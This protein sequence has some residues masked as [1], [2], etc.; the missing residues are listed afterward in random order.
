MLSGE[1]LRMQDTF[2]S[3]FKGIGLALL[4]I[5]FLMVGLDKSFVVPLRSCRSCRS[6]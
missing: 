1:Y 5:Y 2:D 6:A 3:L 4:L